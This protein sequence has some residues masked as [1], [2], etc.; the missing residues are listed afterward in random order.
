MKTHLIV[1]AIALALLGSMSSI[2][3]QELTDKAKFKAYRKSPKWIEM[4][5]D[6]SVNFYEAKLAFE[7]F[8]KEKPSPEELSEGELEGENEEHERSF[9]SRIFKSDRKYKEEITQYAFAHRKFR[10]WL[11]KNAPY[12]KQDGTI[13]S[14]VEKEALVVQELANRA[15]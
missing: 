3:A 10:F 1:P 5:N 11:L 13:M 9:I 6:S 4:M 14:Q 2:S 8:W 12:V 7:T 15:K